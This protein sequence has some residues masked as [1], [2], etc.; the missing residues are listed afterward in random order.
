MLRIEKN[1]KTLVGKAHPLV[2][3][4]EAVIIRMLFRRFPELNSAALN[5]M[6]SASARLKFG[7]S[8]E[9]IRRI[10]KQWGETGIALAVGVAK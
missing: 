1:S 2:S 7:T 6:C 9:C 8:R 4:L 10:I 5:K 3:L